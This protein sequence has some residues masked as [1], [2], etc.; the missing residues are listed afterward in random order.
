VSRENPRLVA[1]WQS[2][3]RRPAEHVDNRAVGSRSALTACGRI[4]KRTLHAPKI[5][6]LEPNML[7][8]GQRRLL[9]IAAGVTFSLAFARRPGIGS[10]K[11]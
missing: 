4:G 3:A 9:H 7:Q 10:I 6:N 11:V 5:G 2:S 1:T 8:M